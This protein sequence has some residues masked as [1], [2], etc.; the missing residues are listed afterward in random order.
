MDKAQQQILWNDII[1][2]NHLKQLSLSVLSGSKVRGRDGEQPSIALR[3][4]DQYS[5]RLS[6]RLAAGTYFPVRYRSKLKVKV[7]FC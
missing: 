4:Y 7:K 3:S 6:N 1:S 2:E 5:V